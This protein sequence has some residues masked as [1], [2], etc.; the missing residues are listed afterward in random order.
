VQEKYKQ[1]TSQSF[2]NSCFSEAAATA[3]RNSRRKDG[4][5]STIDWASG[6]VRCMLSRG[7][8]IVA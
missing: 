7:Q 3:D 6:S 1:E 4:N 2:G 5:V 8:T